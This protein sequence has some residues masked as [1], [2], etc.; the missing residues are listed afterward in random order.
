MCVGGRLSDQGCAGT[1]LEAC[2]S[3]EEEVPVTLELEC[4]AS[5]AIQAAV[6]AARPVAPITCSLLVEASTAPAS[7]QLMLN[8][9]HLLQQVRA[10]GPGWQHRGAACSSSL[11]AEILSFASRCLRALG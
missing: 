8:G 1:G 11:H 3:A 9:A 2:G 7:L 4:Q 10:W 6:D 5:D